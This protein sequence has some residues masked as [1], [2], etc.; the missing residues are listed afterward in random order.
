MVIYDP[1]AKSQVP[2]TEFKNMCN[3]LMNSISNWVIERTH[4]LCF[5]GHTVH[6][7]YIKY[8]YINILLYE[9]IM[10]ESSVFHKQT[11]I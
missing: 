2:Q 4:V 11:S 3:V 6:T 8:I 1:I 10:K 7:I 9:Q 5:C